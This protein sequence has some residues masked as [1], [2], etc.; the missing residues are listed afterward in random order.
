MSHKL[1]EIQR[2]LNRK[3]RARYVVAIKCPWLAFYK[4]G[5]GENPLYLACDLKSK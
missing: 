1:D 3:I 2:H 5:G 4:A